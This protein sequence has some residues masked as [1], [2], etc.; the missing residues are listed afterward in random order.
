[1]LDA[2]SQLG[3]KCSIS[4]QATSDSNPPIRI[5]HRALHH[6]RYRCTAGCTITAA[7]QMQHLASGDERFEVYPHQ[8][9]PYAIRQRCFKPFAAAVVSRTTTLVRVVLVE[10]RSRSARKSYGRGSAQRV[11]WLRDAFPLSALLVAS[12]AQSTLSER[13]HGSRCD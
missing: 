1:M 5:H 7:P 12:S 8:V 6:I 3:P 2:R 10:D 9:V 13:A 4:H 11:S